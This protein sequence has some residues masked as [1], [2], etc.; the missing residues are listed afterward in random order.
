[1]MEV[2]DWSGTEQKS[3]VSGSTVGLP[4]HLLGGQN[5]DR[6][7]SSVFI[8]TKVVF[9]C[10]VKGIKIFGIQQASDRDGGSGASMVGN[11]LKGCESKMRDSAIKLGKV[12]GSVASSLHHDHGT[13]VLRLHLLVSVLNH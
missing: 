2:A 3:R 11:E 5:F 8:G 12:I 9:I 7:Q 6:P 1:M 10:T 13:K 4:L